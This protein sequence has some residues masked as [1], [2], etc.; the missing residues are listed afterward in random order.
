MSRIIIEVIFIAWLCLF[1][2]STLFSGFGSFTYTG[3]ENSFKVN[4][5]YYIILTVSILIL[6][7]RAAVFQFCCQF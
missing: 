4:I 1:D 5:C 2:L 3:D 6:S 7:R